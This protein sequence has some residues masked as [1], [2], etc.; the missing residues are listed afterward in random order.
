MLEILML[1]ITSFI[2]TNID[3]FI[4][5]IFFFSAAE[6][7]KDIVRIVLGKYL[8]ISILL[9]ISLMGAL[10]LEF[11]P[12]QHIGILGL[13]PIGLGI[14]EIFSGMQENEEDDQDIQ[15]QRNKNLLWS[16]GLITIANGA[17]NI[18]VYV[19]LFTGFSGKQYIILFIVFMLMI[20]L[21][22]VLG[23]VA[24]KVPLLEKTILKYKKVIVPGVYILLGMYI[25]KG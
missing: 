14:K 13:V 10:G 16:V 22:C 9:I 17:D 11:L 20:G 12:V 21:W 6:N 5:D 8:G 19:P 25:L 1:S 23:Y 4:I 15:G 18:G 7:K 3:D 24:S 2:G